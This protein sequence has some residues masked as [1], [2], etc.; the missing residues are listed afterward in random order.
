VLIGAPIEHHL[1]E[2]VGPLLA[3]TREKLSKLS[4]LAK[5]L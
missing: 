5:I 4:D 2:I 3:T 1:E